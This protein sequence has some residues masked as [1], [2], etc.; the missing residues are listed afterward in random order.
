MSTNRIL[1]KVDVYV[2][3]AARDYEGSS[4]VAIYT[5]EQVARRY[6]FE[7]QQDEWCTDQYIVAHWS[8]VGKLESK[9]RWFAPKEP[10]E[11]EE[12]REYVEAKKRYREQLAQ[13]EADCKAFALNQ[14]RA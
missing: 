9:D 11:P 13:Y 2:V 6:A 12:P 3:T 7:K 1:E 4:V 10:K 8:G 5:D 14:Q